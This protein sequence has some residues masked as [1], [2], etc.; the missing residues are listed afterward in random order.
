[1]HWFLAKCLPLL[2]RDK[3]GQQ[4]RKGVKV[5]VGRS[6]FVLF[7]FVWVGRIWTRF[8]NSWSNLLPLW[9][10]ISS[11]QKWPKMAEKW[12]YFLAVQSRCFFIPFLVW[13]QG[14]VSDKVPMSVL[15]RTKLLTYD[16]CWRANHEDNK[17]EE[18]LGSIVRVKSLATIVA[19]VKFVRERQVN[20]HYI[21]TLLAS[22]LG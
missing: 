9:T 18:E 8:K 14:I 2:F 19:D 21:H 17:T 3:L 6:M 22:S 11:V 10:P 4:M 1:M 15:A 16:E 5:F 12:K 20:P 7:D 13:N